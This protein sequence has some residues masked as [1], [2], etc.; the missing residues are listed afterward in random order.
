MWLGLEFLA[1]SPFPQN[2][3]KCCSKIFWLLKDTCWMPCPCLVSEC[4][5]SSLLCHVRPA[6]SSHRS[7]SAP[8]CSRLGRAPLLLCFASVFFQPHFISVFSLQQPCLVSISSFCQQGWNQSSLANPGGLLPSLKPTSKG[9][10][11]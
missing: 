8:L 2:L 11:F 6:L 7:L 9:Q 4:P 1:C 5:L 10:L 3:C